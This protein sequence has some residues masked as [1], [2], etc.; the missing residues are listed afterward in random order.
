MNRKNVESNGK[1]EKDDHSES[2]CY[3]Y[4]L[5]LYKQHQTSI[6]ASIASDA[7]TA[8]APTWPLM[9]AT[10][11]AICRCS[12]MS[13]SRLQVDISLAFIPSILHMYFICI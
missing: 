10:L 2:D 7:T 12:L 6:G 3:R 1:W 9:I 13:I 4:G 8:V 5:V 11:A